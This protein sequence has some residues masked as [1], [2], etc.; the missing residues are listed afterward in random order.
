MAETQ[1]LAAWLGGIAKKNGNIGQT[2]TEARAF[3]R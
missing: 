1:P 2:P 3:L